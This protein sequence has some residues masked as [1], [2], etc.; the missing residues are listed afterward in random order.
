MLIKENSRP[1]AVGLLLWSKKTDKE[2]KK[3]STFLPAPISTE[4]MEKPVSEDQRQW[5]AELPHFLL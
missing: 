4:V 5:L 1:R 2:M 3:K